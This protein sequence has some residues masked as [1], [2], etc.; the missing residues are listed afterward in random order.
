MD[1]RAGLVG[2]GLALLGGFVALEYGIAQWSTP[3]A[4]V[5]GGLCL[6]A[7]GL[8]PVARKGHR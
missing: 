6:L 4:W 1:R 2:D 7:I 8:W 5:T 3:A